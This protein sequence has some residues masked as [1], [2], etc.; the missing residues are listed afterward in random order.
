M[1]RPKGKQTEEVL[2][3]LANTL[4]IMVSK[5]ESRYEE[6]SQGIL[7]EKLEN[8][9]QFP[10]DREEFVGDAGSYDQ[11]GQLAATT[12]YHL[13]EWMNENDGVSENIEQASQALTLTSYIAATLD[14][15][16][17]AYIKDSWQK[18]RDRKYMDVEQVYEELNNRGI[19]PVDYNSF[20]KLNID[21][22]YSESS[23]GQSFLGDS[24]QEDENGKS[25]GSI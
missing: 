2:G 7:H 25:W 9:D 11:L 23:E 10:E 8:T 17:N 18:H 3:R 5:F 20:R 19:E 1:E 4:E 6:T 13:A 22:K 21:H 16:F 15:E 14:S 24:W 12:E